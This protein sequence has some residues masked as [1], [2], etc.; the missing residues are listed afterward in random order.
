ME[1]IKNELY[2][3][4]TTSINT[5][6][7]TSTATSTVAGTTV[8]KVLP[9]VIGDSDDDYTNTG[10]TQTGVLV[11]TNSERVKVGIPELKRNVLLDLSAKKKL[12]DMFANQ[13]FEH[14]SPVGASVSDVV[15]STGY[16]FIVAGENLA[17][18]NFGGDP[19]VVAAWMASP[20]HKANILD[21]RYTEV[22]IATGY[23]VYKGQAQWIAVQHFARPMSSCSSPNSGLKETINIHKDQLNQSEIDLATVKKLIDSMSTGDQRLQAT[24]TS[25]NNLVR[26]YNNRLQT[27]KTEISNYNEQV[28]N[29]NSC[30]DAMIS[31]N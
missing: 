23:G 20:G 24:I 11:Y 8:S 3:T 12:D 9:P 31:A 1:R 2:S 7:A 21:R 14:V 29:F 4:A 17:L 28:Q 6:V 19:Q 10:L 26:D 16:D 15:K 22:G 18:G 30:L 27:L 5:E 13:Y 25:Y